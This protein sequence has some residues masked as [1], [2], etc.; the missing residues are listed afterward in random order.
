MVLKAIIYEHSNFQ[1]RSQELIPGN[2]NMASLRIPNDSLSSLKVEP[3]LKV[4][5]F[6]HESFHGRTKTFTENTDW[7]GD[8]FNDITSSIKVEEVVPPQSLPKAIIYEHSNFQGRSQELIPGS[9]N[10][11]SLGIPNDSLSSLKVKKGLKVTLYEHESFCG[12]SKTFTA[13]AAW[14]GDDFNDITSSIEVEELASTPNTKT[15]EVP[16]TLE[17]GIEFTNNQSTEASYTFTPSGT[18]TPNVNNPSLSGCTAAGVKGYPP[19]IQKGIL[20]VV[21]GG[22]GQYMKYPNNTPFALLAV[23]K[24]T[25]EVVAEVSAAT[26][27]SLKPGETLVFVL[28]DMWGGYQDNSGTIAVNC[29]GGSSAPQLKT[30]TV[31]ALQA[32]N[33]KYLSRINRGSNY[34]PIEA[35]KSSIDPYCKFIVTV[36]ADGK[37]ALKA[38]TGKYLSRIRRSGEIDPVEAAKDSIDP[39]CQFT[40]TTLANGKILLQGDTGKYLSRIRRGGIDAIE[41][42]KLPSDVFCQFGLTVL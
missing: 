41:V 32:D 24:A 15:F 19:E 30:G 40:V 23:N 20:D 9:Y 21:P 13:D 29:S 2:Y 26:T 33:D 39:F 22:L 34:D 5:L 12:R 36:L 27:I 38:D 42:A 6:E 17:A 8:D 28:N 1:G 10:M 35:A 4:T 16:G 11:A 18:W 14:V 3:G 7:V 31:I 37:I 25:G